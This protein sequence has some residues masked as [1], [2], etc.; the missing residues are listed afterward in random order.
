[1]RLLWLFFFCL[2]LRLN[3]QNLP[4][5]TAS[6]KIY[7]AEEVLVKDGPQQDLYNRAKTWFANIEQNKKV[8]LVDDKAN[9]VLIGS[10]FFLIPDIANERTKPIN[11][12]CTIKIEV[13]DDRYWYSITDLGILNNTITKDLM[14]PHNLSISQPLEAILFSPNKKSIKENKKPHDLFLELATQNKI[15][16][17]I[18]DLKAAML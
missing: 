14:N 11:L 16:T 12:S 5:D 8:L 3:A 10:C 1:V 7:Y 15:L 9:G 4:V 18:K 13:E 2:P 6:G 17:T